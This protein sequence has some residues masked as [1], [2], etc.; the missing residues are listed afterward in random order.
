[1]ESC[2]EKEYRS[3]IAIDYDGEKFDDEFYAATVY[4][5]YYSSGYIKGTGTLFD[6]KNNDFKIEVEK[7]LKELLR[8]NS[9]F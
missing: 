4:L 9:T 8:Q 1:H 3:Q 2:L 5:W 6:L 7:E